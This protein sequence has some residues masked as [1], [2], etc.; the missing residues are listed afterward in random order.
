LA[1]VLGVVLI[2]YGA[3]LWTSE[4]RFPA[5]WVVGGSSVVLG[6][7]AMVGYLIF[8]FR[9]DPLLSFYGQGVMQ[10]PPPWYYVM[11]YGLL[12]PLALLGS[13]D[14]I[15]RRD[16]RGRLLIVWVVVVF[17]LAYSPLPM[18]RRLIEGVHIPI[19]ILAA[20]GL[21]QRVLPAVA[22]SSLVRA[23]AHLGYP[24]H[25]AVW[26]VRSLLIVTT[27]LS[28]LYLVGSASMAV[29]AR[30]PSLFLS[31]DQRAAFDWLC[32]NLAEDDVV[33]ASHRTGNLIP[34]WTG[35]RVFLG[36]WSESL[37]WP[38]REEQAKAFFDIDTTD[39][40]RIT[41][42][43]QHTITYVFHGPRERARGDFDPATVSWLELAFRSGGVSV[44]QVTLEA[45]P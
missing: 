43:R 26:L 18:Q 24:P 31:G 45:E 10:S 7:G 29:A 17:V 8:A 3:V 14:S 21:H 35:H 15:R 28:N 44:Y 13:V 6:A 37:D 39:A 9:A 1:L 25:R 11:G 19:C 36:H 30:E 33:F 4:R 42:L 38:E 32:D 2:V 41:L 5:R 12:W 23:V 27:W 34:A 40:W 20:A 16:R 22:R